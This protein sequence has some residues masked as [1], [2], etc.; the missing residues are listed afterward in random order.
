MFPLHTLARP[1]YSRG[2]RLKTTKAMKVAS[3]KA[4]NHIA[5]SM[6]GA[7][8]LREENGLGVRGSSLTGSC[9]RA[10]AGNQEYQVCR[11]SAR[12]VAISGRRNQKQSQSQIHAIAAISSA[13]MLSY[14]SAPQSTSAHC[15]AKKSEPNHCFKY[16]RVAHPTDSE[17]RSF[18]SV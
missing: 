10:L 9:A 8:Q 11:V 12:R 17:L 2:V 1:R 7:F 14:T 13:V 3:I 6:R 16:V 15:G 5:S 4:R 18:A